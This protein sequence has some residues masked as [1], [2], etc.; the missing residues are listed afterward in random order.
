MGTEVIL[1]IVIWAFTAL[2]IMVVVLALLKTLFPSLLRSRTR[3]SCGEL[4]IAAIL[5]KAVQRNMLPNHG[6]PYDIDRELEEVRRFIEFSN[7]STTKVL[8]GYLDEPVSLD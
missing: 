8:L 3:L 4:C 2:C 6:T 5:S 1:G 7:A